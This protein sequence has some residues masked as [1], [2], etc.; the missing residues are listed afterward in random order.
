MTKH[1]DSV[2][3]VILCGGR[4]R[5]M[6]GID[7]GLISFMGKTMIQHVIDRIQKQVSEIIIN[8]NRNLD[9]YAGYGHQVVADKDDSFSGPLAGMSSGLHAASK[10]YCV[11]LPCDSPLIGEDIVDRL[12][13]DIQSAD[14]EIA[15]AHDG[16][17]MHPVVTLLNRELSYSIDSFLS[18]GGRKIDQWF[19]LHK[20]VTTDFSDH[21]EY[22]EN[23]NTQEELTGLE[24]KVKAYG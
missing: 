16:E 1:S 6:G 14:A 5:R 17:R 12:Y 21:P 19:A 24:D 10:Q 13:Q 15:V 18:Q 4:A 9:D 11:T 22:F 23:I 2:A 7:K 8:A 3:A 20:T